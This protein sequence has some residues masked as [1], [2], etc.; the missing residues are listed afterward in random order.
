MVD[1]RTNLLKHSSTL[2]EKDFLQ[3]QALLRVATGAVVTAIIAVVVLSI[4]NYLVTGQLSQVEAEIVATT[5]EMQGLVLANTAQ[6]YL[7]NRLSLV[8]NF[9]DEREVTREAMQKLLSTE[10]PGTH[11]AGVEFEGETILNVSYVSANSESLAALLKYYEEEN[12]YFTQATSNG[13]TRSKDGNYQVSLTLLIPKG[14][15]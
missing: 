2:S 1:I 7:K 14:D 3:E 11:V 5:E 8:T 10:I 4:W 12:Q 15:K 6:V 13:I 9:L